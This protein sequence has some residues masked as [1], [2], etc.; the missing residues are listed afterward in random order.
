MDKKGIKG[1]GEHRDADPGVLDDCG[2][3]QKRESG[4]ALASP[5]SS[6]KAL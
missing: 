4:E 6:R 1:F 5:L 2:P 3:P